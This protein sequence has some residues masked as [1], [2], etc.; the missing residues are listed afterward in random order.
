MN[1]WYTDLWDNLRRQS[2]CFQLKHDMKNVSALK[3][4]LFWG[5][6]IFL[7]FL[8]CGDSYYVVEY[9]LPEVVYGLPSA[10]VMQ[11]TPTVGSVLRNG[12]RLSSARAGITLS[13]LTKCYC[14]VE[15][16]LFWPLQIKAAIS[17]RSSPAARQVKGRKR[18]RG[19]CW[20]WHCPHCLFN[21]PLGLEANFVNKLLQLSY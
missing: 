16:W 20:A 6:G 21:W 10:F 3:Y 2:W 17:G 5:S 8:G 13:C 9:C 7:Q 4:F 1:L 11:I 18:D 15:A 19:G 12:G 14:I